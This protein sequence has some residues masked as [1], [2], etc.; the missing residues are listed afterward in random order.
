[1]ADPFQVEATGYKDALSQAE[2]LKGFGT[3]IK[4]AGV[5]I[6]FAGVAGGL[7][8]FGHWASVGAALLVGGAALGLVVLG[9]GSMIAASGQLLSAFIATAVSARITAQIALGKS[10]DDDEEEEEDERPKRRSKKEVA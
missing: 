7:A 4:V 10:Y 1:M 2:A 8:M 6:I 5:V 3:F 9:M